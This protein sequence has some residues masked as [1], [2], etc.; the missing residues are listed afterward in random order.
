MTSL[1]A[2]R[3]VVYNADGSLD[4][5]RGYGA[6]MRSMPTLVPYAVRGPV[7]TAE[8]YDGDLAAQKAQGPL[9]KID[10][11]F[12]TVFAPLTLGLS[13]LA[14]A[15]VTA[16]DWAADAALAGGGEVGSGYAASASLLP[17]PA[18]SWAIDAALAGGGEVG[19]GYA[20]SASLLPA[21]AE[22]GL[23]A[24]LA[25]GASAVLGLGRSLLSA[26]GGKASPQPAPSLA[27]AP[28]GAP[29]WQQ[30]GGFSADEMKT[31]LIAGVAVAALLS[32]LVLLRK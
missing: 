12:L 30:T 19:S 26:G 1:L 7:V 20:A 24:A 28:N 31:F 18:S 25:K 2:P 27:L 13:T 16:T 14:S 6:A 8:K 4:T 17:A 5:T 29:L 10:A 15:A 21:P 3:A 23:G 11:G 32:V 22:A 9:G